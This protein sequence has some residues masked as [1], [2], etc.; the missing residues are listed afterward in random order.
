MRFNT[1]PMVANE[2]HLAISAVDLNHIN[3]VTEL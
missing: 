3:T 2:N 1:I